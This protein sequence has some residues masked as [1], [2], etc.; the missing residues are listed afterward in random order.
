[1]ASSWLT[2]AGLGMTT[3]ERRACRRAGLVPSD[4]AV[5]EP[6]D[7]VAAT[8]EAIDEPRAERLVARASLLELFT[9]TWADNFE[10]FG[11]GSRRELAARTADELFLVWQASPY[12]RPDMHRILAEKI[13]AAGG[14]RPEPVPDD[15]LVRR[16]WAH[17]YGNRSPGTPTKHR[18]RIPAIDVNAPVWSADGAE[19][20]H[21]P[22]PPP[23]DHRAVAVAT[24]GHDRLVAVG[25][26]QWAGHVAAFLRLDDLGPGDEVALTGDGEPRHWSVTSVDRGAAPLALP[27]AGLVLLT[28]PHPRWRPW[29]HDWGQPD[30]DPEATPVQVVVAAD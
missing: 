13:H 9:P 30:L 24:I 29:C 20:D 6:L 12:T 1:M 19:R 8:D 23:L 16:Q 2:W 18:L 3:E 7:V 5:A 15:E 10:R 17:R 28:P 14:P 4:F 11:I 22:P 27:H 26:W 21:W 25:H